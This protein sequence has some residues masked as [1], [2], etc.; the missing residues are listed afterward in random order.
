[1]HKVVIIGGGY[2]GVSALTR[3]AGRKE[4]EVTLIDRHPYHFLQTEGYA[5]VANTL[6]FDSTIIDLHALC[7]SFAPP[8]TFLHDAVTD[9]DLQQKR[10]T[11]ENS[12]PV[13]YDFL[14]ICAGSVTRFMPS[15]EGLRRCSHGVKS[16]TGAFEMKQFFER[17]LFIRLE[18]AQH[19]GHAYSVV[20]GGAGLSGVEIAAEMQHYFNRYYQSNTL[21][22]ERL[23]IH[24]IAGG[25][26]L[27][28]GMHPA[29]VARS[30]ARLQQLGVILHKGAHIARVEP[31]KAILEDGAHVDFDFMLFTGGIMASPVVSRLSLV[32]NKLGQL[33]VD[34][35]LQV[36]ETEALFAAG[37]AA[38]IHDKKGNILPDTAQVAIKSGAHAATNVLRL[39][40][41]KKPLPAHIRIK[42][43]AIALGGEYAILD[44]GKIRIYGRLAH[45]AK[46][47]TERLYRWPLWLRCREGARRIAS[48]SGR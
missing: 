40:Q 47:I 5:L 32:H 13:T 24:L 19:A 46:K 42:G 38:E 29:I 27:L 23:Q 43:I 12:T 25:D 37:D 44:L 7:R 31:D 28:K 1:M 18:N 4:I 21:S 11:V 14:L 20:I 33:L 45:S 39:L 10:V 26:T 9:I 41:G 3:L 15:I 16:L 17:E 30:E 48:Q 36:P 8:A 35:T 2:A 6:P 22:C 34:D